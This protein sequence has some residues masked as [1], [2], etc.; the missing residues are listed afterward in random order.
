MRLDN[1][2]YEKKQCKISDIILGVSTLNVRE[3]WIARK[4]G[5]IKRKTIA[6]SKHAE[7]KYLILLRFIFYVLL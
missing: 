5:C 2:Q 3:R 4:T 6:A 1:M 7:H